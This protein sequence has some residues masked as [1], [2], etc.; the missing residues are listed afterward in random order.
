MSV[1]ADVAWV[2]AVLLVALRMGPLF[3][4]APVFG[5]IQVP[6]QVRALFVLALA[7]LMVTGMQVTALPV[8]LSLA[9]LI[10]AA[11]SELLIGGLFAFGLFT[12]FG[13]F[14]F[15]G[16]ILDLQM[17]FGVASLIDPSSR[18]QAPLLGTFL[19]L[20]AI[21]VFFAIDGHHM[22][23]RGVAFSLQYIPPGAFVLDVNAAALV[24]QFGSMF[25]YAVMIV[26]PAL[27]SIL[28]LDIGMAVM[29]RTMPQVNVFIVAIPLKIFVGLVVLAISLNYMM[30]LMQ[31]IFE[32]IFAY[33]ERVIGLQ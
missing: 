31:N 9:G 21:V 28:L 13:A 29:A 33:W 22:V 12:A 19:N 5:S 2:T 15:A 16:R 27:F 4:L 11:L 6:P 30:P 10:T 26:A 17:G 3:L 8:S 7:A 14:L 32:S 23:L 20:L 18:A 25:V 24:A 1:T